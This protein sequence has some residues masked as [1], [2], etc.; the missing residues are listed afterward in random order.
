MTPSGGGTTDPGMRIVHPMADV[1][2]VPT[3]AALAPDT[4]SAVTTTANWSATGS[5]DGT[6]LAFVSDRSGEP[7]LWV[8][9]SPD[10]APTMPGTGVHP[11]EKVQWSP[12][13]QWLA[14]AIAPGGA[15][16]T[17]VWIMRPDGADQRQVGGFGDCSATFGAWSHGTPS[18]L[19][20]A[21]SAGEWSPSQAF[22]LDPTT[23]HH[24]PLA[25]GG[26]PHALDVAPDH[27]WGLVRHGPRT[28]RWVEIVEIAS[29][30]TTAPIPGDEAGS[31]DQGRFALDGSVVL[32][33]T[34]V[35]RD[36]A[37]LVTAPTAGGAVRVMAAR[38]DAELESF[39]VSGDGRTACLL[40]NVDGGRSELSLLDIAGGDRRPLA[41]PPGEVL[42]WCEL[43]VDGTCLL[44]TAQGPS[45]P[46]NIWMVDVPTG[47]TRP[48]TYG[49]P[50]VVPST[51]VSPELHRFPAEDGLGLSGWLYR[52]AGPTPGPVVLY[53][54][55][56]PEA[57]DRPVF[58]PLYRELVNAGLTVFAPNVRGSSGFGRRFVNADNLDR[59]FQAITDV[60][61]AVTYLVDA[62]IAEPGRIGCMGRS[63][64]GYLTLV[65]LTWHPEL[66]AVGVDVCG[67]VDLETF[68]ANT[69]PWI[70]EAAHSKY[71]HPDRDRDLLRALSPIHRIDQLRAPLLVVHGA[72]DTNVPLH[73]AEQVVAALDARRVPCEFL[74]FRDEGHEIRAIAN[75]T[76]FVETVVDWLSRHL[77][78]D[79]AVAAPA[80]DADGTD[81]VVAGAA[82]QT[83]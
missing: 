12:D 24:M 31:T 32:L 76:Y 35:G 25:T 52:A 37:A 75:R 40:W 44:V 18:L 56:G 39:T 20:V 29:Q 67:M 42:S 10:G 13:G 65:A 66:F 30:A 48:V 19:P 59:R 51:P 78:A 69:E 72:H 57:Q 73:E 83:S 47:D 14:Y 28:A 15:A 60:R 7:K 27:R 58:N 33:R 21:S 77:L 55:G 74:L 62:G 11:V 45:Q 46:R 70:A 5:P 43:S 49:P 80:P 68:Y 2:P 36:L 16:R 3:T 34:D 6:G 41:P 23:G 4:E 61:A 53:L 64:G 17:E 50:Q 9:T 1:E 79:G 22:L 71:G 81:A 38:D 82:D 63:Y 8:R 54:H 26:L